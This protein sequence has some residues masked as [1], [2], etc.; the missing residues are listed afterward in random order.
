MTCL[1]S[2]LCVS[3]CGQSE[4]ALKQLEVERETVEVFGVE[5]VV[6]SYKNRPTIWQCYFLDD[7]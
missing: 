3:V 5:R 1:K 7:G 4:L 2:E 6:Q